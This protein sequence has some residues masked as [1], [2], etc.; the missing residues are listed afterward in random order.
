M[1]LPFAASCGIATEDTSDTPEV[2]SATYR[3]LSADDHLIRASMA[4]RGTRPSASD[5]DIAR[6]HPEHIPVLIDTYLEDPR[7][8]ETIKDWAAEQFLLRTD[9]LDAL[10]AVGPLEGHT[11]SEMYEATSESPLRLVEEVVMDDHPLTTIVTADWVWTNEAHRKIY[12][13]AYDPAGP[14]WQRS[15]WSD[16]RPVAGLLSDSE[17]WR[18]YESAGSNFHRLRANVVAAIERGKNSE[19]RCFQS[20]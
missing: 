16:G 3:F 2:P 12:G 5:L 10:P 1:L 11:L 18:R 13:L 17:M 20:L 15:T 19:A 7:F 9:V 14:A 4:I 8:G 6:D